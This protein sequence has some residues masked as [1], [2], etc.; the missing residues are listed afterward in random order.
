MYS[1]RRDHLSKKKIS[2]SE[3]IR[4]YVI[5]EPK[6]ISG[7]WWKVEPPKSI[8]NDVYSPEDLRKGIWIDTPGRLLDEIIKISNRKLG[9]QP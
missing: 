6:G 9:R 3:A 2:E 7:C 1:L 8:E 5:P 4:V